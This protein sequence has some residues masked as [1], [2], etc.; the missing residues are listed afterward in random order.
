MNTT[1]TA[2]E[3]TLPTTVEGKP[4]NLNFLDFIKFDIRAGVI[5]KAETVPKS[6]KL[7]K[8]EVN[9]GEAGTRTIVAGISSSYEPELVVGFKVVAVLNLAPRTMAGIVSNGMLLAGHDKNGDVVLVHSNG[10]AEGSEI[11]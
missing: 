7:L 1:T 11:G 2:T 10:I 4:H 9:F 8:L 6:K 3:T 5:T